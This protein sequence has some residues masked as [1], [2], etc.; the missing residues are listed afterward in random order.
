MVKKVS[1]L[2]KG[3]Y[4]IAPLLM[5]KRL[6]KSCVLWKVIPAVAQLLF[7]VQGLG[8]VNRAVLEGLPKV[9]EDTLVN[10]SIRQAFIL[11]SCVHLRNLILPVHIPHPN[12]FSVNHQE[13]HV[14]AQ[15]R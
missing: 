9:M 6:A 13:M 8:P 7:V 4:H 10:V 1:Y 15:V 11:P 14:V 2:P 12:C 3:G 5:M